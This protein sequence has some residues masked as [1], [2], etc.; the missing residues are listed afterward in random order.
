[1]CFIGALVAKCVLR[2]CREAAAA[3]A[4]STGS[5]ASPSAPAARLVFLVFYFLI[6]EG[7][8]PPLQ[9]ELRCVP[10]ASFVSLGMNAVAA[11]AISEAEGAQCAHCCDS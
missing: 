8:I 11:S 6:L 5:A 4:C 10:A 9:H 7:E 2:A 1:M 3:N